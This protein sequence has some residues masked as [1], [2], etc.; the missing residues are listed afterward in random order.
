[1]MSKFL[2]AAVSAAVI[3]FAAG[4]ALTQPTPGQSS[5]AASLKAL[6]F[7]SPIFGDDMVLQRGKA[8]TIW[9]WSDP[10]DTVRVQIADKS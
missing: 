8:N 5:A 9:G 4:A 10:G 1:M 2:R 3:L 6:P 7:V